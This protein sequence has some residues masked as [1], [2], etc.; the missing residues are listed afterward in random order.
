MSIYH[1]NPI[2]RASHRQNG[3][4]LVAS[5]VCLLVV[6]AIIGTM[7]RQALHYQRQ[8]LAERDLRQA[9]L[10]V[11]AGVARAA[12]R[13]A[14]NPNYRSETWNLPPDSV[15]NSGQGRV[16]IALSSVAGQ[17]ALTANVVAEYPIGGETSIKRTR[18]VQ[19]PTQSPRP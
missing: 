19:L 13:L 6:M 15:T 8:L 17:P 12:T 14:A 1:C 10:L 3:A 5:L 9:E 4:V 11:D 16:T 18:I 7:L 2:R